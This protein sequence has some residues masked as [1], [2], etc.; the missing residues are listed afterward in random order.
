MAHIL[1][2]FSNSNEI[3]YKVF[4]GIFFFFLQLESLG[5]CSHKEIKVLDEV[6]HNN[7]TKQKKN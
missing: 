6:Y 5:S 4:A 3:K 2:C 1:N 7:R